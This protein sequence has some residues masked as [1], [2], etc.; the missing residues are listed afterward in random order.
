MKKKTHHPHPGEMILEEF[1]KP[2]GLTMY[3]LARMIGVPDTRIQ[4]I[5]RGTA[6]L[7]FDTAQRLDILFGARPGY[8]LGFQAQYDRL[9]TPIPKQTLAK[10]KKAHRALENAA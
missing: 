2:H 10:I 7:D 6:P 5:M 8:F 3:R 4:R 1:A 9:T